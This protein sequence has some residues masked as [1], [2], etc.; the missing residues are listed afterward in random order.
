MNLSFDFLRALLFHYDKYVLLRDNYASLVKQS[1][2]L[3][4]PALNR[5]P[6]CPYSFRNS[7]EFIV[8]VCYTPRGSSEA[9]YEVLA[10]NSE[11]RDFEFRDEVEEKEQKDSFDAELKKEGAHRGGL[12][13]TYA[14]IELAGSLLFLLLSRLSVFSS[15][16]FSVFFA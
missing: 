14:R 8:W 2:P 11:A 1:K 3:I 13:Q 12:I 15:L 5:L 16:L 4:N 7:T 10:A 6:V 9:V